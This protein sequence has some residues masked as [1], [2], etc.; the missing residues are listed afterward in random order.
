MRLPV[1]RSNC[2]STRPG[3]NLW[4]LTIPMY[5]QWAVKLEYSYL[6]PDTALLP[7]TAQP[8]RWITPFRQISRAS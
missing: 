6:S 2:R 5:P 7:R 4:D 1:P 8:A 3:S